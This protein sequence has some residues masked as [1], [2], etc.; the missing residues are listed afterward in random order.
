[1]NPREIP[2][3]DACAG[4]TSRRDFLAQLGSGL[5]GIALASLLARDGL[6]KAAPIAGEAADLPPHHP[7]KARRAIQIF[8]SG[9]LS[10]VDSFDYKPAL[11]K[12]HGQ[13]L[14][15]SE[16]PDVFFGQV[17][18][19]HQS[20][21]AFKQ[22]GQSGLWMSE[23]FP[24]LAECAD[25]LTFVR[26][27]LASSGN[28][29]PAIF[30]ALSGFRLMGFPVMGS[31]LSYGLGCETD[32]LPAFVVLPDPRGL[33]TGGTNNW[34]N[35][36]LPARHQGVGFRSSGPPI[37]DLQSAEPE[38][39][40]RRLDRYA[41]LA[42]MNRAH[43]N[44]RGPSDPLM[45]RVHAYEMAARMQVAIPAAL[46]LEQETAE[47]QALYG[48]D[49]PGSAGFGRNCL[50]ARRLLEKGVRFVQLWS[51]NGPTWDSHGDVPGQHATEAALIDQPIAGLLRDLA[52]RGMLDDTLVIFNTE[53]GARRSR[54]RLQA[55]WAKDAI[56]IRM[57]TPSGWP[58]PVSSQELPT[59]RPMSL[60]ARS[61][62]AP[63]PCTIFMPRF[64]TCLASTTS[65]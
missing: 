58:E 32:E 36:F 33:P 64:C 4:D 1:M 22:R 17:G 52:R 54:N 10:Q 12:Y 62:R 37:A 27:M 45:V 63:Y 59:A 56:T 34:T 24:H 55:R 8:L 28:H 42:E 19:L 21:W 40:K 65:D 49:Q 53:F 43:Q 57:H 38:S 41:L 46:Q 60:A 35:G 47:T 30:E 39:E 16:K 26:S 7:P 29:G 51:G 48:L 25:Q 50:I 23:L 31:W 14:P 5:G 20:H 9:G 44:G 6:L 2:H 11:E 13:P 3:C 61:S 18:L 15:S